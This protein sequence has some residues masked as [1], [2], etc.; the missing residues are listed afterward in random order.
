MAV[1]RDNMDEPLLRPFGGMETGIW[2]GDQSATLNFAAVAEIRGPL[3][4]ASL[5]G[6]LAAAQARHPL[7]RARVRV[8]RRRLEFVGWPEGQT[9]PIPLTVVEAPF[10]DWVAFADHEVQ[11]PLAWDRSPL[12]RAT[13]IRHGAEHGTLLLCFNHVI[14]DGISG[15]FLARDVL[16]AAA[17]LTAGGDGRLEPLPLPPPIED[18]LPKRYRGWSGLEAALGQHRLLRRES[19]PL[20]GVAQLRIDRAAPLAEQRARIIPMRIG[21]ERSR[22]LLAR[23]RA[24]GTTL[25]GL[26]GAAWCL[27]LRPELTPGAMVF[28]SPVNM[29]ARMQPPAGEDVCLLV[30]LVTSAH[31]LDDHTELW[32]L[33]RDI[34]AKAVAG[35]EARQPF[36]FIPA[37]N[38]I[39]ERRLFFPFTERGIARHSRFAAKH[40]TSQGTSG[41]TNIGNVPVKPRQGPLSFEAVH[42]VVSPSVLSSLVLTAAGLAGT[43]CLNL[44]HSEPIVGRARAEEIAERFMEI[45]DQA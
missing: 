29:R 3:T 21:P 41:I 23:A 45:L 26:F 6:A 32:S 9:P 24:E 19:K 13:W 18:R 27:A 11:T 39:S 40:V 44:S 12:V 42:F 5:V 7:L 28:G 15:A 33:A 25:H 1:R 20:G 2:L 31:R 14:G 10:D 43:I 17:D 38:L 37:V 36:A 22:Q 4:E 35:I 8:G 34:R 16:E 30:S